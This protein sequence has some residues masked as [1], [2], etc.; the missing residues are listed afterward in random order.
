MQ[1]LQWNFR[2]FAMARP[3]FFGI[4]FFL[5]EKSLKHSIW[6]SLR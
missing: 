6:N 4:P 3:L 5:G 2:R 1:A